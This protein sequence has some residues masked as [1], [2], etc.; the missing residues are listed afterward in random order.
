MI[1]KNK[2]EINDNLYINKFYSKFAINGNLN[3]SFLM[4]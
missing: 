4:M 2:K 3:N 1:D